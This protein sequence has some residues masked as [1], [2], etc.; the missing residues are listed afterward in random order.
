MR[1][2]LEMVGTFGPEQVLSVTD[3]TTSCRTVGGGAV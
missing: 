3:T 1:T 2:I